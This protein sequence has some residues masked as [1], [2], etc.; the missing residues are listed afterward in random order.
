M[1]P[2]GDCLDGGIHMR[3][4][5]TF[6]VLLLTLIS[7]LAPLVGAQAEEEARRPRFPDS[8]AGRGAGAVLELLTG[9]GEESIA[10]FLE[11]HA[12][13]TLLDRATRE[14]QVET[15]TRLRAE[16]GEVDPVGVR[17]TGP[18]SAQLLLRSRATGA[19]WTAR[20]EL[21]EAEPYRIVELEVRPDDAPRPRV[22][23]GMDE[24]ARIAAVEAYLEELAEA[25]KLSG[26]V[27]VAREG[28][29]LLRR[30]W[31][32][33]SRRYGVANEVDTRYNLGSL[34]KVFTMVAVGLLAREGAL[35]L[36]DPIARYLPE[37]P[38]QQV[39]RTVTVR[40]LLEHT[41]G[42]GDIFTEEFAASSKDRFRTPRDYFPLFTGKP[43]LFAP[44]EGESYSNAGYMVLG[45]IIEAVSGMS[46][47]DYV[48]RHVFEPAGME[49]TGALDADLP[50][51]GV[52]T[53]YTRGMPGH[54]HG[55]DGPGDEPLRENT[56]IIPFRG[57]PAGGGTST[58]DD[59]AAFA[60][61]LAGG[62]L[63]GPA[64]IH[65]FFTGELPAEGTE[66]APGDAFA[67]GYGGG[68]PG[69]S[70]TLEMNPPYTVVVLCNLDP[71]CAPDAARGI[72]EGLLAGH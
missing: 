4:R 22:E 63:L 2:A 55:A 11:E 32:L 30:A 14:E 70:T 1:A 9:K 23:P 49:A 28:E 50:V 58:V 38:D 53:G 31:G 20:F 72:L 25:G 29:P 40:H 7:T 35:S 44:G 24:A 39:A 45:A 54:D 62:K 48:R 18:V 36:D 17:K 47:S 34:D 26:T 33:A 41:S 64:W 66:P 37:Y 16:M 68:A 8:P 6:A 46:Y 10:S 60:R 71:P 15:F 67:V 42:L 43:L 5:C 19:R 57:T 52:A 3:A 65:W 51:P 12:A 59:L 27:L 69:V 13:P 56:F 21:E 61:A